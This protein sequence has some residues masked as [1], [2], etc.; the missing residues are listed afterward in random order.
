MHEIVLPSHEIALPFPKIFPR[1]C[2]E[3]SCCDWNVGCPYRPLSL[4]T[5]FL[6]GGAVS[7][8]HGICKRWGVTGGSS[9]LGIQV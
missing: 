2:L 9:Q 7:G 1:I 6:A 3:H 8:G 4:D 5:G